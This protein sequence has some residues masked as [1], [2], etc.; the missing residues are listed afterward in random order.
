MWQLRIRMNN[1]SNSREVEFS[2]SEQLV[3]IT[4][5]RGVITY[6]ND[7]F[8]RIAGYTPEEL[9]GQH[10]NI[11]R[12]PDMPAAAFG[13]LWAKLKDN[14]PWRGMVKNRCKDGS[15]YWVDAYV[16]PLTENGVVTGY[17]SVRVCPTAEQK[18]AAAAL[19]QQI[20][21]GKKITDFHTNRGLKHGLF[22]GLMLLMFGG[23]FYFNQDT[24]A[25]LLSLMTVVAI[26]AIYS[27]EFFT[28]PSYV[29][30]LKQQFD[31]PSRLV[32]SG[33]GLAAIVDYSLQLSQARLRTVLGRSNDYGN[34]LVTTAV[35]L[36][37]SSSQTL[38]GLMV[39]ND[40]LDQL[41]TAITEMSSSIAEISR[42]TVESKDHVDI[43]N[44]HCISAINIINNT[45]QTTSTLAQEVATA[46]D[47]A[48]SLISDADKISNIMT[49]IGGIADQTN[50]LALNAAI[51]A[52]RAGE[53]G[54]G[55]AVV[56][57]EVRTLASRTQNATAQIQDSVS[58]LQKTLSSWSQM[59][60]EN[61]EQAKQCSDQSIMAREAMDQII[62]MME[63][64]TDTSTQIAATTEEQSVV[65][66][67]ITSSVH[68]IDEI[69]NSNIRLARKL[70]EN[71]KMVQVSAQQINVLSS[72]FQ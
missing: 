6:V 37:E 42:S 21:S 24:S 62:K 53:Q 47:S 57:D 34:N 31:S 30:Q 29:Q 25:I 27:E 4:D 22:S 64:V 38:S 15:F 61:Q 46:A 32:F 40:H 65:A 49:E 39:Q 11:V 59:M 7:N 1:I 43:V 66:E 19:Y 50:L 35:T 41:A 69:S 16:T 60:R 54:R 56:A 70:D 14:R 2:P 18:S 26:L 71:G 12:H 58:A 52:A 36:G 10:H 17:Q 13:D 28:L 8:A 44:Q 63:Q 3:S 20:N 55:F 67:Q 5:V 48:I 51:E 72:T 23:Q 45:E 68:A 33:K 9:V